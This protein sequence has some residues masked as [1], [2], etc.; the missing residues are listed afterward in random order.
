MILRGFISAL[1]PFVLMTCSQAQIQGADTLFRPSDLY[2]F[3]IL[4]RE[5]FSQYFDGQPDYL[6]MIVAVNANSNDNEPELYQDWISDIVREIRHKKF[7]RLSEEKK[8]NQ[9]RNSVSRS[10]LISFEHQSSFSDLF[11]YGNYNY[12]TAASLY[13]FILDELDI[14]HE[15]R[16][17]S[18]G[19]SL[20]A[21]PDDEQITVE[22]DGPG[23][24][25]F[26]FAHDTRSNFVEF[27]RESNAVDDA[28][29]AV[30]NTRALFEQYYFADYGLTIREMI[31]MLYLNSAIDYLNRSEPANA[32][33]QFEKAFILY[34]SC[35]I[36][37]LLLAHLNSFL[38]A[39]DYH[40]LRDLGYLIKASRLIGFG[41]DREM[42]A[43]LLQDIIHEV[44]IKE[45]DLTGMQYI[46]DYMQDYLADEVSKKEFNFLFYYETGRLHFNEQQYPKALESFE[47]A[48][49]LKPDDDN[50]QDLLIRSLGG[51]SINA[52]PGMVLEK[53][54]LYDT[55]YTGIVE[56]EIYQT[57]KLHVCLEFFGEAFQL[58]DEK[59]GEHY[60]AIFEEMMEQYMEQV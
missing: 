5:S 27:L 43:S 32:Y 38:T 22:I 29:F 45:Q 48:Y 36:Q 25:F 58:Q 39:M 20:L 2:Y 24:Q 7:D 53:I 15:I 8:I 10:L 13:A 23:S 21:Y 18:T 1:I 19:I 30:M 9:I 33:T 35:K 16:E 50:N 6:K 12:F 40:N 17:V 49:A 28:T 41:V 60:M 47:T 55:A 59:N 34:P 52:N 4:E 31:G 51:Y 44:L 46:F 56:N 37:Y 42:I 14:P 3:S 26:M 11:R 57:I 54:N